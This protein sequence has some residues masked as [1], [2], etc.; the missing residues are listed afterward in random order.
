MGDNQLFIIAESQDDIGQTER[1]SFSVSIK[2]N[3]LSSVAAN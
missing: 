1:R 3:I 2:D